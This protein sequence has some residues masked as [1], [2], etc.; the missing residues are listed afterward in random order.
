MDGQMW[1]IEQR[2]LREAVRAKQRTPDGRCPLAPV[3]PAASLAEHP[4]NAV[5]RRDAEGVDSGRRDERPDRMP[6]VATASRERASPSLTEGVPLA[7]VIVA[8]W[9]SAGVLARCLDQLFAQDYANLEIVVVDDGSQ[10]DTLAVAE[11]ASRR[12]AMTIVRSPRNRGCP[13]ARNLGLRQAN[14]EII[15]FIDADGF[16]D[17]SWLRN[18]VDAFDADETIGGVASTVFLEGNPLVING[19]GGTVNRQG[20]A[21]DLSMNEPYERAEIASEAL[22]PMGCGM[23]VRRSALECVGPFDDRMLNY[24]DDVDYGTRLWRAGYTVAVVADAWIDHGFGRDGGDSTRKQLLCE[25]HR[26][27]VVLKHASAGSLARWAAHEARAVRRA[28]S[29]RRAL[30]LK[31]MAWN[32]RYLPSVLATRRRLRRARR[33]PDRLVDPSWGDGFPVGVPLLS[34]PRPEDAAHSIDMGDPSSE[35]QLLHGWYPAECV[36]GRSYRWAGVQAAALIQLDAPVSRLRLDYSHVPVDIGGVDVDVR[37]PASSDPL[38]PVWA[39]RLA[40]QY[41]ERSVENHPL[42]LP[43][44]DYEVVFRGRGSWSDPPAETRSLGFALASMSFEESYEIPPGGL[45]M[46]SPAAE[47]QLV[48]GWFEAERVA[49][50]SYRWATGCAAV[51]VRLAESANSAC[52]SYRFPPAP[53]GGLKVSVRPVNASPVVWSARIGWCEGEWHEERFPLGLAAGDYVVAFDAEATWSNPRQRDPERPP[54]NRSLGF[55][56]CSLSFAE[57]G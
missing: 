20:W 36:D 6:H 38:A 49:G 44:G 46:A 37:Q 17:P 16:A 39:T 57:A 8:C 28:P 13:H 4:P 18:I 56:L 2:R 33:V 40:W 52:L 31:A 42:A 50:R 5:A 25:R 51:I 21:A 3:E 48:S 26:M 45:D 53:T 1:R 19:A 43:A 11:E 41:I 7:S 15:A 54:E 23:A 10:D 27:R 32:A 34:L 29:P 30:K 47:E 9:N 12:G 35:G 24:Y 14:G 55:A 22:Y